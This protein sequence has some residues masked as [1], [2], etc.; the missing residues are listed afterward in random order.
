MKM[1]ERIR[2]ARRR[3]GL[4]QTGLAA[5]VEVRRSAVSNWESA[6]GVLPSMQNL[7]AIA[8]ACRVSLEW[9]GTG[10]GGISTDP[11]GLA[12]VP[13][14]DAELVDVEEERTLLAG[15]RELPRRS[16]QLVLDLV[17]TL[18]SSRRR[19]GQA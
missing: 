3:A 7:L 13:A 14:A 1:Q 10:R 4:S 12:D 2:R 6:D 11:D 17:D 16:Q 19:T 8:K 18:H 9:L 15:F 5:L